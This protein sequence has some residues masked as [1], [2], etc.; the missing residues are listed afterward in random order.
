MFGLEITK[1]ILTPFVGTLLV[2]ISAGVVWFLKL[3]YEKHKV[4]VLAL[5]KFERIFANNIT[6]LKDNFDFLDEWISILKQNR[7]YS[8]H[9]RSYYINEKETYKLS[10]LNL[11][12]RIL[13]INHKLRGTSFDFD[14]IYKSYWDVI[15]RIDSIQDKEKREESLKIYHNTIQS[16]L[17]QI[18]QNYK[19]LK[20]D[21]IDVVALVRAV[22]K[23]RCH[24]LFGYI[25][26]IFFID[27]FPRVTKKSIEKEVII[28]KDN[29]ERKEK[30]MK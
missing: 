14:N 28:L 23:V 8:V 9:F 22:Y 12:N 5:S 21:L 4:E 2:L 17:E 26:L 11:I 1:E 3:A 6:I 30:G 19:P 10:N 27:I 18:K 7:S 20:N 16:R 24:S 13:S 29:I 25:S 15:F